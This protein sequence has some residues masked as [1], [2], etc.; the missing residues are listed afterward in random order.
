MPNTIFF[1]WQADTPTREG[2]N[3][4]E[5]SLERAVSRIGQDTD[6]E[7]AIR[8]LAVDK[9]TQGVAGSPPIVE[10]IFQKIDEAAVFVPDLTFVSTRLDGRPSPNPNV[11]VEYGWALKSLGHSRIVPV[12]NTAFGEPAAETMPFDMAHLRRPI[13]YNC[14]AEAT[15][16]TRRKQRELLASALESAIRLVLESEDF[17]SSQPKPAEP[18]PFRPREPM[19]GAGRFRPRGEPLGIDDGGFEHS[20]VK[21]SDGAAVWLRVMPLYD[22]GRNW[23]IAE[24]RTAA[25]H[26]GYIMPLGRGYGGYGTFELTMDLECLERA[27]KSMRRKMLSSSSTRARFGQLIRIYC[28]PP[29]PKMRSTLLRTNFDKRWRSMPNA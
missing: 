27:A 25:T 4:V 28:R 16:D 18:L 29:L 22:L 7:E 10:T 8:D 26:D 24:L 13:P 6:L 14:P 12:M 5:R 3:L 2:R 15:E 21:L 1:S 19:D 11:L 17:K 20:E 9:D 23:R